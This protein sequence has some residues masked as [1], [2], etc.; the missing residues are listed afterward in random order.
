MGW[1]VTEPGFLTARDQLAENW[2]RLRPSERPSFPLERSPKPWEQ[3][4]PAEVVQFRQ[5][6]IDFLDH[7]GLM[8]M[9]TWYLPQPQGPLIPAPI[10]PNSPAM[11][12]HGL[13]I[14]LPIHYPLLSSDRLLFEIQRL[15]ARFAKEAGLDTSVAGLP[16]HQAY[17]QLFE[18][19]H[20]ER[21]VRSRYSHRSHNR[22]FVLAIEHAISDVLGIGDNHARRLRKAISACKRGKRD[23]ISWL[24][25]RLEHFV[26]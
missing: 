15:Q 14:V 26:R 10:R 11:P 24:R 19:E 18:A 7:W 13:H 25:C 2:R 4:P 5:D 23:S 20:I 16:H 21:T 12:K 6:L 1:L 8:S 9:A 3:P 22:G 17:G